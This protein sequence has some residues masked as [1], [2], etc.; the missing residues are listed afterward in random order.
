MD[1]AEGLHVCEPEDEPAGGAVAAKPSAVGGT[2]RAAVVDGLPLLVHALTSARMS[3]AVAAV[4][5]AARSPLPL[6]PPLTALPLI[7]IPP[8]A[9]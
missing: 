1:D 2:A 5:T 6:L 7:D 8:A 3:P 4:F 9:G